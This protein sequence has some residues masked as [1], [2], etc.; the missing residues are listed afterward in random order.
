MNNQVIP[1]NYDNHSEKEVK[2]QITAERWDVKTIEFGKTSSGIET[3][4]KEPI[5][6]YLPKTRP[7]TRQKESLGMN[8]KIG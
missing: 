5:M 7:H 6:T 3:K 8:Y 4:V 1:N 2:T